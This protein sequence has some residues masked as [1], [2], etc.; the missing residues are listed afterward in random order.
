M[1]GKI[2]E[3]ASYKANNIGLDEEKRLYTKYVLLRCFTKANLNT[4]QQTSTGEGLQFKVSIFPNRYLSL[5]KERT[6]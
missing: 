3:C 5:Q 2:I 4:T 6:W 1:V